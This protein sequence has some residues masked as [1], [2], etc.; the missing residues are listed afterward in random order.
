MSEIRKVIF[1]IRLTTG[2]SDTVVKEI[3]PEATADKSRVKDRLGRDL[4]MAINKQN[5]FVG[6]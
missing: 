1:E 5:L 6:D 2:A 3:V 4:M